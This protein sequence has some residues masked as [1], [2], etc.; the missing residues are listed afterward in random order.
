MQGG[1]E[2]GCGEPKEIR[3]EHPFV[4]YRQYGGKEIPTRTLMVYVDRE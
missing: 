3:R 4:V 1:D 2:E